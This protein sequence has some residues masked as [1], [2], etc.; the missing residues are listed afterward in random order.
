[1]QSVSRLLAAAVVAVALL[2]G[3]L[4]CRPGLLTDA[5]LDVW[6]LPELY[7]SIENA[8]RENDALDR[9]HEELFRRVDEK[10]EVLQALLTG[11]LTLVEA[12]ARF[13]EVN[14]Q[15]SKTMQ[16]IREAYPGLSDEERMYQQVLAWV[17]VESD[18]LPG[19]PRG[20]LLRL[21]AEMETYLKQHPS[22]R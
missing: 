10:Q 5:G 3:G 19:Q 1:M 21:E 11:H 16:Y 20:T 15:S 13:G 17:R 22:A 8:N 4:L 2:S 9:D 18:N 6:N 12:A 7:A 14:K